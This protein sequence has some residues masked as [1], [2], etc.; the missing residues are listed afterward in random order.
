MHHEIGLHYT[1]SGTTVIRPRKNSWRWVRMTV[2]CWSFCGENPL[3]PNSA[4]NQRLDQVVTQWS[5]LRLAHEPASLESKEARQ[6][7]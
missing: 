2:S 5:L 3:D 4:A 6:R 7:G 1:R